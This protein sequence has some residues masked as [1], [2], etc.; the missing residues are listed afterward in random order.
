M[1]RPRL[2]IVLRHA[3]KKYTR[4]VIVAALVLNWFYLL[5]HWRD[6]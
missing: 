4:A 5:A 2:R 6:F 3:E 1:R